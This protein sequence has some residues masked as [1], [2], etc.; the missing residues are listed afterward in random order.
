[1]AQANAAVF[2]FSAGGRAASADFEI[3]GGNLQLILSNLGTDP[4]T[5]RPPGWDPTYI[6]T[7][8]TFHYDGGDLIPGNATFSTS[9]SHPESGT[10]IGDHWAFANA[11]QGATTLRGIA[12]AGFYGNLGHGAFGSNPQN[13]DGYSDGIVNFSQANGNGRIPQASLVNN[14]ITFTFVGAGGL[15]TLS[16]SDFSEVTFLYG[17]A[18][19]E[20]RH[21]A[22]DGGCTVL[23]MGSALMGLGLLRKFSS[24]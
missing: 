13:I 6:L 24:N 7:G 15:T 22:P 5:A 14:S 17:T 9:W 16:E 2:S 18:L 1:M 10:T 3:V 23:L 8:L 19:G 11:L 21:G 4:G 12:T 20:Y